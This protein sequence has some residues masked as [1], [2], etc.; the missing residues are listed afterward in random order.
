[1]CRW[2]NVWKMCFYT[3]LLR[4]YPSRGFSCANI[5]N[6][7][8]PEKC[9]TA[10]ISLF[11]W[12]T[13]LLAFQT[14]VLVRV[15][16]WFSSVYSQYVSMIRSYSL[17]EAPQER[18][19]QHHLLHSPNA[20]AYTRASGVFRFFPSPLHPWR[21]INW[22]TRLCGWRLHPTLPFTGEGLKS[23]RPSH[24]TNYRSTH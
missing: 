6:Y 8:R 3:S 17:E 11:F 10:K 14:L 13:L 16:C 21:I 9:Y 4:G 20:H 12:R 19:Q 23:T 5:N 1:M 7:C 22:W 2:W 18:F 15:Y 24:T